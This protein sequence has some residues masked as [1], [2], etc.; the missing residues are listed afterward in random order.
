MLNL[1]I[2]AH[3]GKMWVQNYIGFSNPANFLRFIFL[4]GLL[5]PLFVAYVPYLDFPFG[6]FIL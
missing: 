3:F 5:L 6:A 1:L 2:F 4:N